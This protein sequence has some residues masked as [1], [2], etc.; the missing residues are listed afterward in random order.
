MSVILQLPRDILHSVFS[1]WLG[2]KDLSRLDSACVE[3]N[4]RKDWLISLTDLRI[5]LIIEYYRISDTSMSIFYKWVVSRKVL[6]VENFPVRLKVLRDLVGD[7]DMEYYC[8]TLRSIDIES[9]NSNDSFHDIGEE[10]INLSDFLN[11][12]HS[13]QEVTIK[14]S[15]FDI[16]HKRLCDII[17]QGLI[18]QLREN[19]LVKISLQVRLSNYEYYYVILA[20]FII[21][22]ASSLQHFRLFLTD[23]EGTNLILCT[24]LENQI[25]LRALIVNVDYES[26]SSSSLISYISTAGDV[27][28]VLEVACSKESFFRIDD[29]VM[30]VSTSCPK[31]T[32]LV[33]STGEPCTAENLRHLYEQCPCLYDVSIDGAIEIDVKNKWVSIAVRDSNDDWAVSLS[34]TLRRGQYKNV[35]LSLRENYYHPVGNLKSMLEP[36]DID[37]HASMWDES[38][39]SILQDLPHLNGLILD[40]VTDNQY[41]DAALSAITEHAKSLTQLQL[42][43]LNAGQSG[44]RTLDMVVS[45]LIKACQSLKGLAIDGCGWESI[46]AVSK[47][48]SLTDVSFTMADSVSEEM[49]QAFVLD[50]K[51]DWPSTLKYGQAY[52]YEYEFCYRFN[53]ESHHWFKKKLIKL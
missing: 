29:L 32:R 48:T 28:E 18:Q 14:I 22:H 27:L 40:R 7:L 1:E 15:D 42:N 31:L 26:S 24:L 12:C 43:L 37:L 9:S 4:A 50:E 16:F 30:L 51:V 23:E 53:K 38:L 25:Y 6:F 49:L 36:F 2:C 19:S 34:Y 17:F 41:T 46:V 39:I 21:R 20:N 10:E 44:A 13:L 3:K 45:E 35:I 33:I 11:H 8:P 5:T 47:H 52:A